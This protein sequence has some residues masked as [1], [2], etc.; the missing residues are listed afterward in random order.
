MRPYRAVAE[1]LGV[2]MVGAILGGCYPPQGSQPSK[3]RAAVDVN[4]LFPVGLPVAEWVEF[5]AAGYSGPVT[6]AVYRGE[7]IPVCGVPLGALDTGSL[8]LEATGTLGYSSIFNHLSP[9]GGPLNMPFLGISVG[10]STWVLT[11]GKTKGYAGRPGSG[12]ELVLEGVKIADAIDYWGHFPIADLEYRTDC[13]VSVGLRAWSPLIPG[14]APVS[15]TPGAVFEVHLRNP[16]E[17]KQTGTIAFSFPGFGRHAPRLE[18]P[19]WSQ[20]SSAS[21]PNWFVEAQ[22]EDLPQPNIVRKFVQPHPVGSWVIDPG[23]KMSYV[24]AVMGDKTPR[25]GGELGADGGKWKAIERKLPEITAED[26]GGTSLA[27]DFMLEPGAQEVVRFVLAWYAPDWKGNGLPDSGGE[28]YSH[29]YAAR[30]PGAVDVARFLTRARESLLGRV[31]AWQE[32]VYSAP[33]IPG[34]LADS[35]INHLYYIAE[36]SAWAQA[37]PPIGYWCKPEDGL[38]AMQDC[39]RGGASMESLANS[40]MGSLPLFYFFPECALSNLRAHKAYQWTTTGNP[41]W[42]FGGGWDVTHP[43]RGYQSVMN[44]SNYMLKLNRYWMVASARAGDDRGRGADWFLKEFY[45][46]AKAA[47][48]FAFN[49]RPEYGFSQIIATAPTGTDVGLYG[50]PEYSTYP[51]WFLFPGKETEWYENM[52]YY[53]YATHSGGF[54]MAH[55]RMMRRWAEKMGDQEYVK[56][57]EAYL[58]AGTKALEK[59]LWAGTHYLAY[60]EP[61]TG[62]RERAF[63]TPQLSGQYYARAH[64]L[65]GVFPKDRVATVLDTVRTYGTKVTPSGIPPNYINPEGTPVHGIG[66]YGTY[67][68]HPITHYMLGMTYLYEGNRAFGLELIRKVI[69][70]W[71]IRWGQM[72]DGTNVWYANVNEDNLPTFTGPDYY[73]KMNLWGAPAALAGEDIAGTSRPG[74]LVDRIIKAGSQDSRRR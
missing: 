21:D 65:P 42:F 3:K 72:W 30:F 18:K 58:E 64:G 63:F 46:S 61:E 12:R 27:V 29:M 39:G 16:G 25:I 15:N 6:G 67:A 59:H 4:R 51:K 66:G 68:F 69:H 43:V 8:D 57:M 7:P 50:D 37:K 34:W 14:D 41:A 54:R 48:E 52:T 73:L 74:G 2:V 70:E 33:E 19:R 24:L 60:H 38:F 10:G 47:T 36:N 20:S 23:W 5:G 17:T 45:D 40:A 71:A 62:R 9:R 49:L 13:P 56:R 22:E 28:T 31:L 35:L 1:V 55:A 11:T 26:D 44:G 53:G 32:A